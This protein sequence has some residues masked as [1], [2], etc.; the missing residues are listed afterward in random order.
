MLTSIISSDWETITKDKYN[1]IG[2]GRL[3]HE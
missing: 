3:I 1:I 2:S